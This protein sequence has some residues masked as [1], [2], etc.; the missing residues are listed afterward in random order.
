MIVE[1]NIMIPMK[2][3]MRLAI[4]RYRPHTAEAIPGSRAAASKD[5]VTE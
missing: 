2:D 5:Q 4:D 1:K 3:D